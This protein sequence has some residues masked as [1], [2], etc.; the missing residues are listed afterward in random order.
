MCAERCRRP[1][2]DLLGDPL[3]RQRGLLEQPII[4]FLPLVMGAGLL[5]ASVGVRSLTRG[6]RSWPGVVGFA[7]GSGAIAT[8]LILVPLSWLLLLLLIPGFVSVIA[9]A[10]FAGLGADAA[11]TCPDPGIDVGLGL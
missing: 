10:A 9:S 8:T 6:R 4:V 1:E 3:D 2:P 7:A 11:D 5:A